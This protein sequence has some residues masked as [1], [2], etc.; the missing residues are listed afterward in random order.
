MVKH[1]LPYVRFQIWPSLPS[2]RTSYIIYGSWPTMSV[3]LFQAGETSSS[4][5][6]RPLI[7]IHYKCPDRSVNKSFCGPTSSVKQS[8]C[9][10]LGRLKFNRVN[11]YGCK[12]KIRDRRWRAKNQRAAQLLK[13]KQSVVTSRWI[14]FWITSNAMNWLLSARERL[15]SEYIDRGT[16]ARAAPR[17]SLLAVHYNNC[18]YSGKLTHFLLWII[19]GVMSM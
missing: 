3:C 1:P 9:H 11:R 7:L 12:V 8:L 17:E 15:I 16:R 18:V 19:I 4:K 10:A 5:Y 6:G 13:H 14:R 2:K